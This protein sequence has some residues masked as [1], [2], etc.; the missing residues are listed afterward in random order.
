MEQA[1]SEPR[2]AAVVKIGT[3]FRTIAHSGS[4]TIEDGRLTLRKGSGDIVA[5]GP[6]SDVWADRS[7]LSFGIG[8]VVW[9]GGERYAIMPV[10]FNPGTA[11]GA[12]AKLA[13]DSKK[14]KDLREQ[15]LEAVEAEGGHIGKPAE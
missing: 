13:L 9:V 3:R 15:F 14:G 12:A 7:R 1:A 2:F 5:D 10:S 11:A 6:V 8:T 4:A